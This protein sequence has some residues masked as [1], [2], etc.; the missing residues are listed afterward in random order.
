MYH[1]LLFYLL[2]ANHLGPADKA[3]KHQLMSKL[4]LS[5]EKTKGANDV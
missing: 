2:N 5:K 4:A 3:I 1:L